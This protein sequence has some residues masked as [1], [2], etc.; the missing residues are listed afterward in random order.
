MRLRPYREPGSPFQIS[1]QATIVAGFAIVIVLTAAIVHAAWSY[2]SS[3]N[4]AELSKRLSDQVTLYIAD[5]IEGLLDDAVVAREAF[6]STVRAQSVDIKMQMINEPVILSF[7]K[8]HPKLDE[9]EFSLP[10]DH[11]IRVSRNKVGTFTSEELI[12][13]ANS[14]LLKRKYYA[15]DAGGQLVL[16]REETGQSNYQATR[17]FWYR[18]AFD[19]DKP[20]W[21]NIYPS[22]RSGGF[23][24]TTSETV[25]VDNPD[26]GVVG[27]TLSLDRFSSFLNDISLT[28]GSFILLT[29]TASQVIA[30]QNSVSPSSAVLPTGQ[31]LRTLEEIE[32]PG[33]RAVSY[34]IARNRLNLGDLKHPF[35]TVLDGENVG[36]PTFVMLA[37]LNQMGLIVA[38]VTPESD[39][40]GNVNAK[41]QMLFFVIAVLVMSVVLVTAIVA[42]RY[43]GR[44]LSAVVQNIHYLQKFDHDSIVTK[45]SPFSEVTEVSRAIKHMNNSLTSFG[46]YIPKKLVQTLFAQG[47]EAK[48]GAELRT[49]T[50]LFVDLAN[51]THISEMLGDDVAEFLGSYLS[52]ISEVVQRHNGTIDKYIGD[53][54]MA[55]W[56]APEAH[57]AHALSACRAA[58]SSRESIAALR[59]I[60]RSRGLPDVHARIGINTGPALVG[61]F[62]STD[63]LNYTAIGDSVNV[64]SR[65]ESLNKAYGTEILIGESTYEI[66]RQDVIARLIDRVSVYGKD[67]AISVYELISMK[68]GEQPRPEWIELYE[69]GLASI[70][71]CDWN[72]AVSYFSRVIAMRGHDQASE[73]QIERAKSY[74]LTPPRGGWDG[75][76]VMNSK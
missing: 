15:P 74:A 59:Q 7:F 66:V 62:G 42:R 52:T 61:N 63:R 9:M 75:R 30:V 57:S 6:A 32:I 31:Q 48:L 23:R 72:K 3:Q 1:L 11:S 16:K 40:L 76:V 58:L 17:Q 68:E 65:L 71:R 34:A 24:V 13:S 41:L 25:D 45:A 55:F 73:K 60:T 54:V 5:K 26:W 47:M 29:N 46:K 14:L 2:T 53:S 4:I 39:L 49:M 50:T 18:T 67:E 10:S 22:V 8:S 12:P 36:G 38:I 19:I 69:L 56:G 21:S 43:L 37:P 28:P 70:R 51:F 44:P 20:E 27:V 64:A 35:F 33:G